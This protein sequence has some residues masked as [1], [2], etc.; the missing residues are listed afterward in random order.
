M[1]TCENILVRQTVGDPSS[2]KWSKSKKWNWSETVYR[3]NNKRNIRMVSWIQVLVCFVSVS[4]LVH[5]KETLFHGSESGPLQRQP[6][7]NSW[8]VQWH[9]WNWYTWCISLAGLGDVK[10]ILSCMTVQLYGLFMRNCSRNIFDWRAFSC[11]PT[12]I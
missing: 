6:Q 1:N 5:F 4:L 10:Y 7:D 9:I 3:K 8:Y 11:F 12:T 2:I